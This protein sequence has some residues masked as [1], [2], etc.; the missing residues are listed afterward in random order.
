MRTTVN[1]NDAI[2]SEL[3]NRAHESN[4]PCRKVL[5]NILQRGLSLA[6]QKKNQKR[7]QI[8]ASAVGINPALSGYS[9]NQLY[10]EIEAQNQESGS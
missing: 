5:H 1:I 4:Q 7:V 6:P 8:E 10:D 3:K 2:L 9:M